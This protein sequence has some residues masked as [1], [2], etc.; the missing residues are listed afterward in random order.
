MRKS[1]KIA[2][3]LILEQIL[4]TSYS[5]EREDY[6]EFSESELKEIEEE[7]QKITVQIRKRYNL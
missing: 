3:D 5:L 1:R 4:N 7:I 6:S 2:R